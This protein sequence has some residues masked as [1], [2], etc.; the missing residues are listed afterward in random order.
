VEIGSF[1]CAILSSIGLDVCA[2]D[3]PEPVVSPPPGQ[4]VRRTLEADPDLDYLL[5][6]PRGCGPRL[7][8]LVTVHGISRNAETHAGVFSRVAQKR[9]AVLVAPFFDGNAFTDY[10]R[11]GRR[12]LGAR[13]DRALARLVEHVGALTGAATGGILLF[14][15]SGGAQFAHRYA[16]AYPERVAAAVVASPGWYTF[17]DEKRMYP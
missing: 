4:L 14:G 8:L 7:P 17:P 2:P 6:V 12:N 5:Y 11:L 13:A 10:Q 9:C 1:L 15:Y 16:L 3:L